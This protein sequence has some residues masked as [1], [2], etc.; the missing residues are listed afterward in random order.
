MLVWEFEGE[1]PVD[2]V[3]KDDD[4]VVCETSL[5][6]HVDKQDLNKISNSS[7][8]CTHSEYAPV[9]RF[10]TRITN[11]VSSQTSSSECPLQRDTIT[12]LFLVFNDVTRDQK[13]FFV[14]SCYLTMLLKI[15]HLGSLDVDVTDPV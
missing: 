6:G 13:T 3:V 11:T 12:M 9:T 10:S 8:N 5:E 2:R 1:L 15:P 7:Q 14:N 4:S